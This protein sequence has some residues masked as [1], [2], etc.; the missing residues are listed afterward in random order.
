MCPLGPVTFYSGWQ[1][2]GAFL[3]NSAAVFGE[4]QLGG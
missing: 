2:W 4:S 1:E 3:S